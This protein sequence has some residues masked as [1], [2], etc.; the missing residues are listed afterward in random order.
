MKHF[1]F[2]NT[3]LEPLFRTEN[4]VFSGYDDVSYVD[5]SAEVF[6]WLYILPYQADSSILVNQIEFFYENIKMIYGLIPDHKLFCVFTLFNPYSAGVKTGDFT[7][8][9]AIDEFNTNIIAFAE[10]RSNVRIINMTEFA[11]NYSVSELIDWKYY[12]ISKMVIN[13]RLSKTFGNWFRSHMN[14]I[15]LRRKKCLILDLDNT[16]WG[17]ILG[18]DGVTG[19]KIGGDYPGNAFT[20]FQ[21]SIINL[22]NS[23]VILA[24]CSKN[25]ESDVLE[26][27]SKNPDILIKKDDISAYRINWSNKADNIREISDELNIGLNSMVFIDDNPTERELVKQI[28]PEVSTPD[29]P[30]NPYDL[31]KLVSKIVTDFFQIYNVT[32]EDLDKTHQYK[33]NSKRAIFKNSFEDF[34]QYLISLEISLLI[35][36]ASEL[37]IPRIA[38]M[39]QKTNQFNFTTYRYTEG[40]IRKFVNK[41]DWVYTINVN[42]KFG[43]SGITGL[44]IVELE[45]KTARVN[46]FLLSCRILGKNIE[47]AFIS[48]ILLKLKQFGI[49]I[50][51]ADYIPTLKNGQVKNF[52]EKLGF[53]GVSVE[54]DNVSSRREF[55]LKLSSFV[56]EDNGIF[57]TKMS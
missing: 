10:S 56:Y 49:E 57:K 36:P 13:P 26:A 43:N 31:P 21:R 14:S 45:N 16:L 53:Q 54:D 29:F 28:L 11:S 39:T 35:E 4:V 40:D 55:N 1:I 9:E 17:G 41:G 32:A 15:M 27:W 23:G 7:V 8:F 42:D 2:R 24:V 46:S 3:T 34:N 33:S 30:E 50:V 51:V 38:Q 25:N 48:Y 22:K 44:I 37:S 5:R 47:M 20:E 6:S 12:F 19:I 52:Y 18:E